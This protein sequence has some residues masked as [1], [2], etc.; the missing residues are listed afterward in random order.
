[1]RGC[2]LRF[3][4]RVELSSEKPWMIF[5]FYYLNE[6]FLRIQAAYDH[7][8]LYEI[9]PVEI[10]EF[11]SVTMAFTYPGALISLTGSRVRH[12]D[13]GISAKTHCPALILSF[14]VRHYMYYRMSGFLIELSAVSLIESCHMP[15]KFNNRALHPEAYSE[16]WYFMLPR[17]LNCSYFPLNTPVAESSRDNDT[18][19]I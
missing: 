9:I 5:D 14:L 10:I 2:R 11:I 6:I 3:E 12:K 7:S 17:I 19:Y 15:C 16:K 13:A 4:F 18:V 1:M 8:C